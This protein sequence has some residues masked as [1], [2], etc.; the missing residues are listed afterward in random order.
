ME[1]PDYKTYAI[2]YARYFREDRLIKLLDGLP[3]REAIVADLCCGEGRV[4]FEALK[5]GASRVW[6]VDQCADMIPTPLQNAVDI[7]VSSV[8]KALALRPSRSLDKVKVV[9][10]QQ[11]VNYWLN[12]KSAELLHD[13]ME[14]GG[15]FAFN[16]F[17]VCPPKIPRTMRY[18]LEERQYWECSY[19]I[20]GMVH[21]VQACEGIPPHVTAFQWLSG[22]TI[23]EIM[24]GLFILDSAIQEG[25]SVIYHCRKIS[26]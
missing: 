2:L 5:R 9:V 7:W 18:Q 24:K 11:G 26:Q 10:C 14:K 13:I 22:K 15:I 20:N 21:H 19:Y 16:T 8:E 3:F 4:S 17:T 1:Y 25:S 6:A 12:R 23:R